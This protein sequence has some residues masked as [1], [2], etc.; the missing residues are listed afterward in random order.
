[1]NEVYEIY[2]YWEVSVTSDTCS[3]YAFFPKHMNKQLEFWIMHSLHSLKCR[4]KKA[5]L[6]SPGCETGFSYNSSISLDV[7]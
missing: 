3:V 7:I 2:K 6:P 4:W 5:Q 1:M